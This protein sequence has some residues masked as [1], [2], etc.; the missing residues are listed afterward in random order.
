MRVFLIL[1][2]ML[3]A[4]AARAEDTKPPL[5]LANVFDSSTADLS[6]YWVSEKYDGIRAY[7]NGREL[8]TRN[9]HLIAAPAWFTTELPAIPLDGELWIGRGRFEEVART[10]R[11][12]VP[13]ETAWRAVRFVVFDLPAHRG[14]FDERIRALDDLQL[15]PPAFAVEQFRVADIATLHRTLKEIVTAGGE[16]LMLHRSDSH[17]RSGRSDDLLKLKPLLDAEARVVGHV[18]GKGKY[19]GMLGALRVERPDGV[20]FLLGT[21][22]TDAQRRNPPEIGTQVTYSFNGLTADGLPRFARF[23]RERTDDDGSTSQGVDPASAATERN[24]H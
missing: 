4:A 5:L 10:V 9:G 7:W 17:Y 6:A 8:L 1:I 24:S 18:E 16:G 19:I 22:F 21:G 15:A 3:L 11:D 14:I 13:D 23:V 20:Q 2:C 12:T